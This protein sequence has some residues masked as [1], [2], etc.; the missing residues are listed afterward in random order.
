MNFT[1]PPNLFLLCFNLPPSQRLAGS[2]NGRPE[3]H[4]FGVNWFINVDQDNHIYIKDKT[5][6]ASYHPLSKIPWSA[7]SIAEIE[8]NGRPLRKSYMELLQKR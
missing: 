7:A 8:V 3:K 1:E 2:C 5:E 6:L 4:H